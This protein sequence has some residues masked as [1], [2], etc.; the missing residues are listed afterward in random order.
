[1]TIRNFC[2]VLLLF[3]GYTASVWA[4]QTDPALAD[5]FDTLQNAENRMTAARTEQDIWRRWNT[6][7]SSEADDMLAQAQQAAQ[8]GNQAAAAAMFERLVSSFPQYAEA[9]NQRAIYRFMQGDY[10]GALE[11]I[12]KTLALEPR[13]FGALAGRGQCYMHMN[14]PRDALQAFDAALAVNPWMEAIEEWSTMIRTM[15]NAGSPES[16]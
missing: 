10:G 6:A 14:Q 12:A 13:H 7:P 15:L 3:P 11:D 4:D 8:V 5:L 16:I 2:F 9:W 1:M